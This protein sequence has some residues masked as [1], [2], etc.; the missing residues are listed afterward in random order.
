MSRRYRFALLSSMCLAVA[1][2]IGCGATTR[3]S[4]SWVNPAVPKMSFTK[5]AAVA[6]EKNAVRRMILEDAMT[7]ELA[8]HGKAAVASYTLIPDA[9][10]K[11]REKARQR[12]SAAGVDGVVMMRI[13]SVDQQT[14]YVPGSIGYAPYYG[15]AWGYYGHWGTA[16]WDP[17]YVITDQNVRVETVV[18]SL[19]VDQMVWA[20]LSD[21]LNPDD[22]RALVKSVGKAAV[23]DMRK[24]GRL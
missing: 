1:T 8:R 24:K 23:E 21:T 20:G 9:D 12:L 22:A 18:Y 15:S 5:I 3:V 6:I 14:T 16:I 4:N 7:A 2:A 19:K 11:D 10:L 17:G 13:T